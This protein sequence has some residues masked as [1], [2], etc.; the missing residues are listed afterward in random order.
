MLE[1]CSALANNTYVVNIHW[2]MEG[3]WENE[4]AQAAAFC[5]GFVDSPPITRLLITVLEV[6]NSVM[7][8]FS[9]RR[10]FIK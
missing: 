1:Q 10:R 8:I 3:Q 5:M 4:L 2:E 7:N 9:S 6:K